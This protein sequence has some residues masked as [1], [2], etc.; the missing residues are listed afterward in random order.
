[1][2]FVALPVSVISAFGLMYFAGFTL[3][4]ISMLALALAIGLLD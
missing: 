3:N 1:M 2:A 4:M